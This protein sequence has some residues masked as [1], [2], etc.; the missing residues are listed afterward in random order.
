[1]IHKY[2]IKLVGETKITVP[3]FSKILTAINQYEHLVVY[4]DANTE[5]SDNVE[6][7]VYS[8][9]TGQKAPTRGYLN[10]VSF[11]NGAF[12]VHVFTDLENKYD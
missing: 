5:N 6:M 1:M 8:V 3:R 11:D 12:I 2:K 7:T 10:T 9:M 4:V